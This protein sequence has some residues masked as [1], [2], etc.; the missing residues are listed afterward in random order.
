MYKTHYRVIYSV[1][2]NL[3]KR[4]SEIKRDVVFVGGCAEVFHQIKDKATDIDIVV[5]NL[6]GLDVLGPIR[7]FRA[8]TEICDSKRRGAIYV[9]DIL[10]DIFIED[11]LP[12]Y[13]EFDGIKYQT[14]NGFY[15]YYERVIPKFKD[16]FHK[17]RLEKKLQRLNEKNK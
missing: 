9:G 14:I 4:I 12:E 10:I 13:I 1:V 3:I 6:D 11:K 17:R 7:E 16:G 5:L 8:Q 15:D 2:K